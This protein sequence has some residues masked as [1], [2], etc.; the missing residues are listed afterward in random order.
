[1]IIAVT[2]THPLLW[3]FGGNS[4]RLGDEALKAFEGAERADGSA[5]IYVPT[6][7]LAECLRVFVAP[8]ARGIQI[9]QSFDDF[10]RLLEAHQGFR[11]EDLRSSTILKCFELPVIPDPFEG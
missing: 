7:V 8:Q 9:R 4:R 11:I 6:I 3:Y 2:D 5:L 1:V 10:V